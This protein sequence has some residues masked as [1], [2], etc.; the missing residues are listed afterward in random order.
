MAVPLLDL[1]RQ[2]APLADEIEAAVLEVARSGQWIGGPA[3]ERFERQLADYC[4]VERAVAISSGSDALLASLMAL[5]IGPG[6]EV[7]TTPFTFFA[8]AGAIGRLGAVPVFVD[9]RPRTYNLDVNEIEAAVTD[10]DW[11]GPVAVICYAGKSSVPAAKLLD[12]H[13]DA[14]AVSVAGGYEAWNGPT[15]ESVPTR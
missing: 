8:T 4:G 1:K 6:D 10:R 7:I 11:D 12:A 13:T 2:Y 5:D 15:T 14:D 3:V 9:I